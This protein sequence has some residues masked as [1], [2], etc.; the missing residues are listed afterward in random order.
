MV[1]HGE[2]H[3]EQHR[4]NDQR[5]VRCHVVALRIVPLTR[6]RFLT[7]RDMN[8]HSY[9]GLWKGSSERLHELRTMWSVSHLLR[10]IIDVDGCR[11]LMF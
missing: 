6:F 11:A 2:T 5:Y 10:A 1:P 3:D 8:G 7:S 4:Q 9:M